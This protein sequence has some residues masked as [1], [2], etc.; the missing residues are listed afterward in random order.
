MQILGDLSNQDDL[1]L[2]LYSM[3]LINT[4]LNS[5]P[6]QDT[7]YDVSDNFEEQNMQNIIKH[8]QKNQIKDE[9]DLHKQ[10]L[11]QMDLYEAALIQEDGEDTSNNNDELNSSFGSNSTNSSNNK[12]TRDALA[13]NL[14]YLSKFLSVCFFCYLSVLLAANSS[15]IFFELGGH[16]FLF[17]F[18][19]NFISFRISALNLTQ[20]IILSI[21][22]FYYHTYF[23]WNIVN[24]S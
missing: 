23:L 16:L 8:Y 7:F 2:I 15:C 13:T 5:I 4:V 14:R 11:Q 3:I 18:N 20:F 6:D 10:I 21:N 12:S 24:N 1:E 17:F 22:F 19:S 9:H